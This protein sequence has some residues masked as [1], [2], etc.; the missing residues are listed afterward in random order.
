MTLRFPMPEAEKSRTSL[1]RRK[2][3]MNSEPEAK[4]RRYQG[5]V[6]KMMTRSKMPFPL[7]Q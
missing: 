5:R 1:A 4:G 6:R 7:R 3:V 2:T